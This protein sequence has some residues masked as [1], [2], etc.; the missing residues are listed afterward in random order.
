[1]DSQG[2]QRQR[3]VRGYTRFASIRTRPAPGLDTLE[4]ES[5]RNPGP[6]YPERIRREPAQS[7]GR[8]AQTLA[9]ENFEMDQFQICGGKPLHGTVRIS[10]AKN[11][12]LPAM[13][14]AL[15]TEEPVT[16]HNVPRV[17]DI[18]TMGRLLAFMSAT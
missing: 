3:R 13:A 1:M 11:S 16:L 8:V 2:G 5:L 12:A 7:A 4:T 15:L 10:G 17:R 14:A 18:I 9:R 6:A